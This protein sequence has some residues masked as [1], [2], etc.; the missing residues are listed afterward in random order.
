MNT[1]VTRKI[2]SK[3]FSVATLAA[4]SIVGAW[5]FPCE[6]AFAQQASFGVTGTV[7]RVR[8]VPPSMPLVPVSS[9]MTNSPAPD[10]V[11]VGVQV[12]DGEVYFAIAD[13]AH[14]PRLGTSVV[15]VSS[16]NGLRIAD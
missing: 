6:S 1:I 2:A 16:G 7:V 14:Q 5:A 11:E 9:G 4:I 12:A 3:I 13:R 15:L 8:L 10:L